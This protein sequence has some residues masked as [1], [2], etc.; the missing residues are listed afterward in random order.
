MKKERRAHLKS[1]EA[2]FQLHATELETKWK[3]HA[4]AILPQ[5][6]NELSLKLL[7]KLLTQNIHKIKH[8][9][10]PNGTHLMSPIDF[11]NYYKTP[12]KLIKNALHIAEQ[13]FCQQRC[14][15]NCSNQ[16]NRYPQARILQEKYISNNRELLSIISNNPLHPIP[17]QQP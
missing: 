7:Y 11:Q 17:P 12:I 10:L 5:L 6:N 8:I 9:F 15:Q 3:S 13:F 1:T 4:I 16:C 14:N 2:N